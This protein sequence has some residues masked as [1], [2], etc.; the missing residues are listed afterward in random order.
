MVHSNG[1]KGKGRLTTVRPNWVIN[2]QDGSEQWFSD[3]GD[4][5]YALEH[6]GEASPTL[7]EAHALIAQSRPETAIRADDMRRN[8]I[9]GRFIG[10]GRGE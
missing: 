7:A 10:G 1:S 4:A 3:L 5:F 2:W 6:N 9:T 8:P